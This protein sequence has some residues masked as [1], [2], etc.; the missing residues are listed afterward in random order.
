MRPK[1]AT[2]YFDKL[3]DV[4]NDFVKYIRRER[5]PKD[6]KVISMMRLTR[7]Q[8]YHWSQL[9]V[10]LDFNVQFETLSTSKLKF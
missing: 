4:S 9:K 2:F 3:Q 1:S 8:F 10:A 7:G 6:L 5:N